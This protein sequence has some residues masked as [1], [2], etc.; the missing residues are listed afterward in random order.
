MCFHPIKIRNPSLLFNQ[1][2]DKPWIEVPCGHCEDCLKNKVNDLIVR[3]YYEWKR[4]IDHGGFAYFDTLTYSNQSVPKLFGEMVF[5]RKHLTDFFK[6]VRRRIEKDGFEVTKQCGVD[7]NGKPLYVSRLKYLVTTE[8]GADDQYSKRPHYHVLWFCTVPGLRVYDLYKYSRDVWFGFYK[9]GWNDH[10]TQVMEHVINRVDGIAYVCK[11]L[12]KKTDYHDRLLRLL[13][14][15]KD[16]PSRLAVVLDNI[17]NI[18]PFYRSSIGF[19]ASIMEVDSDTL[20]KHGVPFIDSKGPSFMPIPQYIKNKLFY[21]KVE[22]PIKEQ[23]SYRRRNRLSVDYLVNN[24][25]TIIDSKVLKY[26]GLVDNYSLFSD[27]PYNIKEYVSSL[28]DGRTMRD[29]V[30]YK[31]V[32][33]GH[34]YSELDSSSYNDFFKRWLTSPKEICPWY[35]SDRRPIGRAI[36][37]LSFD[38]FINDPIHAVVYDGSL[39]EFASFDEID[40]ILDVL[41]SQYDSYLEKSYIRKKNE[42]AQ[43]QEIFNRFFNRRKNNYLCVDR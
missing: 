15:F 29:F 37:K 13:N 27:I 2:M 38:N 9:F 36:S 20:Q 22:H 32:Y 34:L 4:T 14:K 1:E 21:E 6:L 40:S 12:S 31:C 7:K 33:K 5:S 25:D 10:I 3:G 8:Y 42:Q 43:N 19:G 11:Y 26:Q 24:L 18:K 23:E 35:C 41:S 28:L 30:I 17:K 39:P 16:D